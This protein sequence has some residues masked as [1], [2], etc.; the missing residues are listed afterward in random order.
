MTV[1]Y[2]IQPLQ[3]CHAAVAARLHE[4]AQPGTF[5]TNLGQRF[6]RL[7]Y[8]EL[9]DTP[10]AFGYEAVIGDECV[11][12]MTGATNTEH[13]YS[14]IIRRRWFAFAVV[15][16]LRLL[17]HPWLIPSTLQTLRYP[18]QLHA[19]PGEGEA[20]TLGVFK[21]YRHYGIGGALMKALIDGARER[22]LKG[23]WYTVDATNE[24]AL[25]LHKGYGAIFKREEM[26][27]GRKM[28]LLLNPLTGGDASADTPAHE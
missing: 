24:R 3:R 2:K 10:S 16:G 23:L 22:G 12:L 18:G 8:E 26:L 15:V 7:L 11:G 28:I 21:A 4:E 9:A 25:R 13:L 14:E 17:T 1:E 19:A 27:N 5:L 20:L 6:L